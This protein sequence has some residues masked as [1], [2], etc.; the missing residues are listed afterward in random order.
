[1]VDEQGNELKK[2]TDPKLCGCGLSQD[3]PFCDKSHANYVSIVTGMLEAARV[4]AKAMLPMGVWPLRAFEIRK[5]SLENRIATGE[6]LVGVKFGGAL[7]KDGAEVKN[8]AGI[9]GFLTDAMQVKETLQLNRLI[10]P[11]AEAEVVFKLGRDLDREITF[12]EVKNFISEVAPGIEVFDC[13][14]GAIDPYIDDAVAD[15]ACAGAYAVGTWVSAET[16]DFEGATIEI[17]VD[18]QIQQSVPASEIAGNPWNAVVNVSKRLAEAGVTLPT[19]SIIFSGSA[20]VGIAMKPGKYK[21][22][23]SGLG[24]VEFKANEL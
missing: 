8:Y 4:N 13:R 20:T 22:A 3:K 7:L 9:F 12:E 23:I 5:R 24:E 15:N 11:I 2:V 17:F 10:A 19:G 16:V 21:V 1:M 18:D 14:Y 6:K